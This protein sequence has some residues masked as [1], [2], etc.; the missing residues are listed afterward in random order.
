MP[1]DGKPTVLDENVAG[2]RDEIDRIAARRLPVRFRLR[3]TQ[4]LIGQPRDLLRRGEDSAGGLEAFHFAGA[5]Q[6]VG[7]L[8]AQQRERRAQLM[9][10]VGREPPLRV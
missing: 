8:R 6:R 3:E 1:I 2:R 9:R 10:R 4:E 5:A 7:R